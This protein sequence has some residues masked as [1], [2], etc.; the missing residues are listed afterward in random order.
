MGEP[1]DGSLVILGERRRG[2]PRVEQPQERL[3]TRLPTPEYD[4]LVKLAQQREQSLSALVRDLLTI[5]R[6][7]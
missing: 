1:Q 2:R 3:S 7:K 6:R 5:S 4:R